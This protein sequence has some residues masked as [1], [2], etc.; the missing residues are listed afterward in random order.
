M[1]RLARLFLVVGLGAGCLGTPNASNDAG[2][3]ADA[4]LEPGTTAWQHE[5]GDAAPYVAMG[6]GY[7][8]LAAGFNG[9]LALDPPVVA[10]G[11]GADILIAGFAPDGKQQ[12][13]EVYGGAANEY[14]TAVTVSRV[15]GDIAIFGVYGAGEGNIG[16]DPLPAPAGSVYHML[17]ARYGPTGAHAWSLPGTAIDGAFSS[18]ALSM[19]GSG[20]VALAGQ[21]S[22]AMD[23]AGEVVPYAGPDI[24]LYY[25]RLADTGEPLIGAGYGSVGD[26]TGAGALFDGLGGVYLFG[27]QNGPFV[28]DDYSPDSD[29]DGGL[30]V[31]Q[32]DETGGFIDTTWLF[33]SIGGTVGGLRG[34]VTPD[35]SLVL[36]GWFEGT[37]AF[38]LPEQEVLVSRG[39]SDVFIAFVSPDGTIAGLEQ[40]GGAGDDE[41]RGV[42]VGPDGEV[43]ITGSFHADARLGEGPPLSSAGGAD[44]FVTLLGADHQPLW[45]RRFG[46]LEDDSGLSVAAGEGGAV[47]VGALY[48][49]V[50]D[51]GGDQPL[52]SGGDTAAAIIGFR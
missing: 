1:D 30:F 42:A 28:I 8:V 4:G 49:G 37:F 11:G 35:G 7:V 18:F 46:G 27:T 2:D 23:I 32:L 15:S 17:V 25:V 52:D 3:P 36:T 44:M 47:V 29:G 12:F 31:C 20:E 40:F 5:L 16:G 13:A 33:D 10:E 19:S 51:F 39:G 6:A 45:E 26:Q 24:D 38:D 21:E 22:S 34:A 43:A 48:R 14:V 50:V 9:E 41:P